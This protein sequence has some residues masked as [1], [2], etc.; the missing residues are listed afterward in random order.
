M[1]PCFY[2]ILYFNINDYNTQSKAGICV[3]VLWLSLCFLLLGL[4]YFRPLGRR[5]QRWNLSAV[6]S[7]RLAHR[8]RFQ[9]YDSGQ[10]AR[11]HRRDAECPPPHQEG[12]RQGDK[13]RQCVWSNQPIR[14]TL[15]CVQVWSGVLQWQPPVR[16]HLTFQACICVPCESADLQHLIL[17]FSINMAPFGVKVLCIEPGF[18]KTN[19]TDTAMLKN[20]LM[21][22]WERLPQ[23][24][25]D[26]YGHGFLDTSE[27][28]YFI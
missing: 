25:K 1:W 28:L 11:C 27:M 21:K 7:Q 9:T 16:A 8:R 17:C 26:D 20:N 6:R 19:V 3:S 2:G 10:S 13:H 23:E 5:E 4:C 22:L 14:R 12:Q 18:F 24:V 15:L